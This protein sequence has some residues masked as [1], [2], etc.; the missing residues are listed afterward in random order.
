M[1]APGPPTWPRGPHAGRGVGGS[2]ARGCR[3]EP[4]NAKA[5]AIEV[6]IPAVAAH[7]VVAGGQPTTAEAAAQG[8]C[9]FDCISVAAA[10]RCVFCSA[11]C[12]HLPKQRRGP[13]PHPPQVERQRRVVATLAG[14]V[15]LLDDGAG[16][17]H[18][19]IRHS[20]GRPQVGHQPGSRGASGWVCG[21]AG[22]CNGVGRPRGR[23]APCTRMQATN[24]PGPSR[25]LGRRGSEQSRVQYACQPATAAFHALPAHCGGRPAALPP[26]LAM[27]APGGR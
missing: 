1:L 6:A 19:H 8:A 11:R 5:V 27:P 9:R 10:I 25:T 26:V 3:W 24:Q 23:S 18:H 12:Q 13:A 22:R 14:V 16:G 21:L 20:D 15:A 4:A 2:L 17:A 7:S